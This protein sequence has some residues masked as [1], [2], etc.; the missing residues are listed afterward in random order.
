M[1]RSKCEI[2]YMQ[3]RIPQRKP[4]APESSKFM[5]KLLTIKP[6]EIEVTD[7]VA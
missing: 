7:S 4:I 5:K 3:L 6:A 2:I 1:T